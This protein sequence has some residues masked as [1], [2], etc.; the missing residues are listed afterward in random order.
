MQGAELAWERGGSVLYDG[1]A[2][3]EA[4]DGALVKSIPPPIGTLVKREHSWDHSLHL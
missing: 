4:V 3:L 2:A 1:L